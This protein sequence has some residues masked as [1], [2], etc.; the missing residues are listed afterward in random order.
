MA[1]WARFT[2]DG[3]AFGVVAETFVFPE[4][5]FSLFAPDWRWIEAPEETKPGSMFDGTTWEHDPVTLPEPT[6]DPEPRYRLQIAPAEFRN[7]FTAFEEVDI[8]AFV[9]GGENDDAETK[10]ARA[11]VG[12]LFDRLLDPRLTYVDLANADNLKGLAFLRDLKL[13]TS[14]RHDIIAKGL[15][16]ATS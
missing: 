15:P 3:A 14:E 6:P 2:D 7:M 5:P 13:I 1:L 12:V 4:N 10:R 16:E 11:V 8:K 9:D